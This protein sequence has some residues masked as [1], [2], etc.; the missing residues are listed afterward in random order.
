M[1]L[2]IA[3]SKRVRWSLNSSRYPPRLSWMEKFSRLRNCCRT[4]TIWRPRQPFTESLTL[5]PGKMLQRIGQFQCRAS[6]RDYWSKTWTLSMISKA[7]KAPKESKSWSKWRMHYLSSS[8]RNRRSARRMRSS[9]SSRT[10]PQFW[11]ASWRTRRQ[12]W[13]SPQSSLRSRYL[14]LRHIHRIAT[15]K[16]FFTNSSSLPWPRRTWWTTPR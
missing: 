7:T 3:R 1:H 10:S 16:S 4:F 9:S 14:H 6:Y 13:P 11:S 8:W 2:A 5:S 15:L 12:N